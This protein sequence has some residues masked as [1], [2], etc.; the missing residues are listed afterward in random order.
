MSEEL[1]NTNTMEIQHQVYRTDYID[2]FPGVFFGI[3]LLITAGVINLG[4]FFMGLF[5]IA[6]VL[7]FPISELLRKRFTYPR[8]GYFKIKSDSPREVLPRIVIFITVLIFCSS[9]VIFLFEGKSF[10]SI[11]DVFYTYLPIFLGLTMFALSLDIADKTG[12][13]K[14]LGLGVSCILLGFLIVLLDF[15]QHKD[16]ITVYLLLLG[17][18]TTIL[19]FVTFYLFLKRYPVISEVEVPVIKERDNSGTE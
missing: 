9:I 12:Q 8:L 4:P 18:F 3:I 17:S 7:S 2:G 1:Q 11:D 19:G 16:G 13:R 5:F 10:S 14:Y 6:F 15:P